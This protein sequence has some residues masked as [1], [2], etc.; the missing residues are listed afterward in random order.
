MKFS[1]TSNRANFNPIVEKKILRYIIDFLK[2]TDEAKVRNLIRK[3][4]SSGLISK[5]EFIYTLRKGIENNTFKVEKSRE[6]FEDN[7][8]SLNQ[9]PNLDNDLCSI[10]LVAST[11]R[12]S[13]ISISELL[14]RNDMLNMKDCFEKIF[15]SAQEVVRISS[16]FIQKNVI[17]DGVFPELSEY[18][19]ELFGRDIYVKIITRNIK[20]KKD[21]ELNWIIETA[22]ENDSLENLE[23]RDYHIK[24]DGRIYASTHAKLLISDQ[25]LSYVGSGELR[26]NSLMVNLEL[27]ALIKGDIVTSYCEVFDYMF[28]KG[29][30]YV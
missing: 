4:E 8:I 7:I 3:F 6:K 17:N 9:V 16:P 5:S 15:N 20:E 25:N 2:K 29:N 1:D 12:L 27:G 13:E 10:K 18:F 19:E 23:I 14:K 21:K 28:E 11:P 26:K 24:K 22:R 30:K